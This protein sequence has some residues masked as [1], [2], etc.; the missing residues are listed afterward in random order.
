M[1]AYHWHAAHD[2]AR[3]RWRLRSPP[4]RQAAE[5]FAPSEA[6][7]HF[8]RALELWPKLSRRGSDDRYGRDRA[9]PAGR[10]GGAARRGRR[11]GAVA[12]RRGAGSRSAPTAI[13][14]ASAALLEVRA[15]VLRDL[16][17]GHEAV[18]DA[19]KAVALLP[20]NRRPRPAPACSPCSRNS[21][22]TATTC[23]RRSVT[24]SAP[25][26]PALA[27]G[28]T[29]SLADARMTLGRRNASTSA[30]PSVRPGHAAAK[31]S[32]APR[33]TPTR[34]S[35]A[36]ANLV[37]VLGLMGRHEEAVEAATRAWRSPSARVSPATWGAFVAG[38]RLESLLS[39]GRWD[40]A[41]AVLARQTTGRPGRRVRS[42]HV[43]GPRPDARARRALRGS[44]G[45][46]RAR[47]PP[48]R[49]PPRQHPV[50]AADGVRAG[51]DRPGARRAAAARAAGSPTGWTADP[52]GWN[53]RYG[54]PLC[55]S[56][57]G[58]KWR[59]ARRDPERVA[60]LEALARRVPGPEAGRAGRIPRL[61]RPSGR[62]STGLDLWEPR[63]RPPARATRRICAPTRRCASPRRGSR[64]ATA[65]RPASAVTEAIA[66]A[67]DLGAEP[68]AEQARALRAP[69]AARRGTGRGGRE[70]LRAHR[71]ASSRCCGSSRTGGR[72]GRSPRSCSSAARRRPC[73][74]PTSS[75]SSALPHG[76]RRLP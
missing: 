14:S 42:R 17:R 30:R 10:R 66:L 21:T 58:W 56:G 68:I 13:A 57:C 2:T 24:P 31:G 36:Y 49:R 33:G 65:R 4:G 32:P 7:R 74:S 18:E 40:E 35:A 64:P 20:R 12:A 61:P 51:G 22:S 16:G 76:A 6:Q 53:S 34:R 45:R 59:A 38:N 9:R 67:A 71:A 50:H 72:T 37:D 60:G 41:E 55:G 44:G 46:P 47:A 19:C 28:E 1:L 29:R 26:P 43:R 3:A 63:S 15:T 5:T 73:T 23:H 8:E 54:W 27:A 48:D 11:T 25:S 52:E 39:L 62:G 70:R 75:P 69:R